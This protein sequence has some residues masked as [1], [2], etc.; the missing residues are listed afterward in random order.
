M[1]FLYW[2]NVMFFT[3]NKSNY[4]ISC[5]LSCYDYF[6]SSFQISSYSPPF[7]AKQGGKL[8]HGLA[9][10]R[11]KIYCMYPSSCDRLQWYRSCFLLEFRLS[12]TG[13]KATHL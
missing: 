9:I 13:R 8:S 7:S 10:T 12:H 2:G 5:H 4:L 11:R 6:S 3:R 1:K